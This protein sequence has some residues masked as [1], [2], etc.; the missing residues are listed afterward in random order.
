VLRKSLDASQLGLDELIDEVINHSF[1]KSY[2]NT[3]HQELH[4]VINNQVL[5]QLFYLAA[6]K[7]MYKQVNAIVL[8]K[9]D[10][11]KV[12]LRGRQSKGIQK[13][14]DIELIKSIDEFKKDP[15]TY[16]KVSAPKIPDGSPIG[17]D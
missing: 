9:L 3:Y 14:Y 12:L 2:K 7:N 15:S 16:K 11:I 6:D 5:N 10:E 17:M 13:M 4:N 8:Y 1:K